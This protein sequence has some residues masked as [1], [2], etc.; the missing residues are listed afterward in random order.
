MEPQAL[1]G[2]FNVWVF[3][4]ASHTA[5]KALLNILP[6]S[7]KNVDAIATPGDIVFTCVA[8]PKQRYR[9]ILDTA[10]REHGRTRDRY[11][12]PTVG[13]R[14][15]KTGIGWTGRDKDWTGVPMKRLRRLNG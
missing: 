7:M 9:G 8:Y 15:V 6:G 14:M 1:C 4:D 5:Y 10:T 3:D 12:G 13:K 11:R 2:N